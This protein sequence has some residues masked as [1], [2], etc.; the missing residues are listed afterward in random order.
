MKIF[1]SFGSY[2]AIQRHIAKQF[3]LQ[4]VKYRKSLKV[5]YTSM[6]YLFNRSFGKCPFNFGKT[7]R[8]FEKLK[9]NF[10]KYKLNFGKWN[11]RTQVYMKVANKLMS[12]YVVFQ[13]IGNWEGYT[14][15]SKG[16]KSMCMNILKITP[17]NLLWNL[18]CT[19]HGIN[20]LATRK[21]QLKFI[22]PTAVE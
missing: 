3:N 11:P 1:L 14:T 16:Y 19:V 13:Q 12:V 17:T 5:R 2:Y 4:L 21:T 8:N 9:L 6:L 7:K 18:M 20:K 22:R 10:G 15:L